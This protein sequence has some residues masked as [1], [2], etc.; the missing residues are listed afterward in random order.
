MPRPVRALFSKIPK[1]SEGTLGIAGIAVIARNRRDLK[2]EPRYWKTP[3]KLGLV[4]QVCRSKKLAL[5]P[6]RRSRAIPRDPGD[7]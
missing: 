6:I 3:L 5:C 1:R 2:T 4:R 7:V